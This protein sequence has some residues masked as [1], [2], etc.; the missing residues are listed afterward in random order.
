M[1]Q[2]DKPPEADPLHGEDAELFR[3]ERKHH[4]HDD[5]REQ[6]YVDEKRVDSDQ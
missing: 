3:V 6:E 2:F 1:S 4:D 5:G